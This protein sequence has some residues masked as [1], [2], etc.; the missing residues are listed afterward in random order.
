MFNKEDVALKI[1]DNLV[2]KIIEL[3]G[4]EALKV[5]IEDNNK[6]TVVE[7]KMSEKFKSLIIL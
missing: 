7:N 3:H 4:I 1:M 6:Q 2:L 5:K